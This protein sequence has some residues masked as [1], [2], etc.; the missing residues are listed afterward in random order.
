LNLPRLLMTKPSYVDVRNTRLARGKRLG[1]R[2]KFVES[3]FLVDQTCD[4]EGSGPP[5]SAPPSNALQHP[6]NRPILSPFLISCTGRAER[7]A[8]G[9]ARAAA[10]RLAYRTKAPPRHGGAPHGRKAGTWTRLGRKRKKWK[11]KKDYTLRICIQSR[12]GPL[13]LFLWFLCNMDIW[14]RADERVRLPFHAVRYHPTDQT[15]RGRSAAT[16]EGQLSETHCMATAAERASRPQ[17][18][19]PQPSLPP[20]PFRSKRHVDIQNN[21]PALFLGRRLIPSCFCPKQT[22]PSDRLARGIVLFQRVSASEGTLSGPH[23]PGVRDAQPEGSRQR[24]GGGLTARP[25]PCV[26]M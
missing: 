9:Q 17:A 15:T 12:S 18:P 20:P 23:A 5:S 19:A 13:L 6:I 11:R 4:L 7:N 2:Q 25:K 21:K 1:P 26:V 16:H 24:L 10:R 22:S 14:I 8:P 3:R